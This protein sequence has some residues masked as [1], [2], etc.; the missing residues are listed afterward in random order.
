MRGGSCIG[1][2]CS[3]DQR[4]QSSHHEPARR[5]AAS[6]Q[7]WA[8]DGSASSSVGTTWYQAF[9]AGGWTRRAR[10]PPLL[11]TKRTGPLTSPV[12]L[13]DDCHGTMWSLMALT[14][15]V[16]ALIAPRSMVF[17]AISRS[18]AASLFST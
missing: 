6:R 3:S 15:Y 14:T 7:A 16:G 17:P 13:Y 2:A 10:P 11:S 9:G 4:A 1:P 18:P 5:S 12:V 8:L